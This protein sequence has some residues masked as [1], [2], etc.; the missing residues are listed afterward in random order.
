[1]HGL[2]T[3]LFFMGARYS[4]DRRGKLTSTTVSCPMNA[5]RCGTSLICRWRCCSRLFL[6][7]EEHVH[8]ELIP[9]SQHTGEEVDG[10]LIFGDRDDRLSEP[11][12][13]IRFTL[14]KCFRPTKHL[15]S[16]VAWYSLAPRWCGIAIVSWECLCG[17]DRLCKFRVYYSSARCCK[18]VFCFCKT[19][20]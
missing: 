14:E 8:I 16:L 13:V 12:G 18:S 15:L 1:M 19:C 5:R 17:G 20:Q 11:T 7:L 2:V 4:I 9:E 3:I 10:H 6:V